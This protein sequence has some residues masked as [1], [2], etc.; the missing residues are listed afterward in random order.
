MHDAK[1]I[2]PDVYTLHAYFMWQSR[3][4]SNSTCSFEQLENENSANQAG[5]YNIF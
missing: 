1:I 4:V 2:S 3:T 5:L